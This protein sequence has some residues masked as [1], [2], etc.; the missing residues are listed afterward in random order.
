MDGGCFSKGMVLL[1]EVSYLPLEPREEA[2]A[3]VEGAEGGR[4]R[5]DGCVQMADFSAPDLSLVPALSP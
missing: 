1:P 3:G 4:G 2:E 5:P